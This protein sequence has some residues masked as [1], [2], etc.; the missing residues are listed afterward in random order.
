MP[1]LWVLRARLLAYRILGVRVLR[2]G[3]LCLCSGWVLRCAARD[4]LTDLKIRKWTETNHTQKYRK[5]RIPV[6][7]THAAPNLT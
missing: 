6:L 2:P 4:W 5:G 3:D 1:A 7:P